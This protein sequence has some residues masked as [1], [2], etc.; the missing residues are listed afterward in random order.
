MDILKLFK[1]R[2]RLYAIELD[3]EKINKE[4]FSI[5]TKVERHLSDLSG[6]ITEKDVD[7]KNATLYE[8]E[9]NF[10]S[11]KSKIDSL[12]SDIERILS[13]EIENK[14]YLTIH[15][16]G[17]LE[18][19]RERLKR[20]SEALE[21]LVD[22]IMTRPALN[23]LRSGLMNEIYA[24]TNFLVENLNNVIEDDKNL[25]LAYEKLEAL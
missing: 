4:I 9:N 14:E 17:Y 13:I 20:M 18:D 10:L 8:L 11:M 24:R 5:I 2:S 7:L 1:K 6:V 16:D 19:K 22:L 3:D 15:D 12:R 21:D 25:L 23:D